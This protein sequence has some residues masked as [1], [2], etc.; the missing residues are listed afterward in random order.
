MPG[1]DSKGRLSR[2]S[3]QEDPRRS[4]WVAMASPGDLATGGIAMTSNAIN[5][6]KR[7]CEKADVS[8]ALL[9]VTRTDG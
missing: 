1:A 9:E 5:L 7:S 8:P 4:G 2:K 3:S 6:S